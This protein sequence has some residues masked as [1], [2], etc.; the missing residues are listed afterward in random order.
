MNIEQARQIHLIEFLKDLGYEPVH[1]NKHMFWFNSPINEKNEIPTFRINQ[2]NNTWMDFSTSQGGD[3][4]KLGKLLYR[5][6]NLSD[7]L[8]YI[9]RKSP[10]EKDAEITSDSLY[11][12]TIPYKKI[13]ITPLTNCSLLSFLMSRNI[14]FRLAQEICIEI[15]YELYG[16]CFNGIG[17]VNE[18]K[19]YEFKSSYLTGTIGEK[20]IS[21]F[22]AN[23]NNN[24]GCCIFEDFIDFLSFKTLQ[25]MRVVEF[26][27]YQDYDCIILNS[28]P[29]LPYIQ[30]QIK[31]YETVVSLLKKN[32][33]GNVVS[34]FIKGINECKYK[35]I[36]LLL[37]YETVNRFLKQN[38]IK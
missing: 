7:V 12:K 28:I 15:Q 1:Q 38:A 14:D 32:D 23:E 13:R 17:I 2:L 3:I 11:T 6:D 5:T 29:D 21:I 27:L 31:R 35:E 34:D 36:D 9:K 25:N 22:K 26:C 8:Q 16:R 24:I 37:Q 18:S 20:D 30:K 33:Y 4:I 19:G 10:V